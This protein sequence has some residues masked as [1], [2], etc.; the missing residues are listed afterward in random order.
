V[1]LAAVIFRRLHRQPNKIGL[2]FDSVRCKWQQELPSRLHIPTVAF[3]ALKSG[4][5]FGANINVGTQELEMH[6]RSCFTVVNL[7]NLW[8]N[9]PVLYGTLFRLL[10]AKIVSNNSVE[11]FYKIGPRLLK[12]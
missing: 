3:L 4:R 12:L 10:V 11:N 2:D 5:Y 9:Y 8:S 1:I 6:V 7:H